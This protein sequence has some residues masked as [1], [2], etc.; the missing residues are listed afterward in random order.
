MRAKRKVKKNKN[1]KVITA[2]FKAVW[3]ISRKKIFFGSCFFVRIFNSIVPVPAQGSS[4]VKLSETLI[5]SQTKAG[6]KYAPFADLS[7]ILR[8]D[9]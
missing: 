4:T 5:F 6:V 9:S 8:N 1:T 2:I 7:E 3:S